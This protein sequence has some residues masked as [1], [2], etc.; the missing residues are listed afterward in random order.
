MFESVEARTHARTPARVPSYKL[1]LW[2]FGS[3]EL[4]IKT[5]VNLYRNW[6][7]LIVVGFNPKITWQV[8]CQFCFWCWKINDTLQLS[9]LLFELLWTCFTFDNPL[10]DNAILKGK[11]TLFLLKAYPVSN[12]LWRCI[13]CWLLIKLWQL[14]FKIYI[15]Q[16][17]HCTEEKID[18]VLTHCK[19][20]IT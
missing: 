7:L 13:L 20:A 8:T 12:Y 5:I 16:I 4:K 9:F 18:N 1:T 17:H 10:I 6:T 2:A 15:G 11:L 14:Y 19:I 3:G